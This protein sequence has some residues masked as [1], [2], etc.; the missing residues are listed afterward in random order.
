MAARQGRSRSAVLRGLVDEA[1]GATDTSA[2]ERTRL[3]LGMLGADRDVE[4]KA[5]VAEQHDRYI[6][7]ERRR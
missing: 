2:H 1:L 6:Y 4:G 7:G 3:L 5:D